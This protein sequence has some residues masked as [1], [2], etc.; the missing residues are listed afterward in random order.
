[1]SKLPT[2]QIKIEPVGQI[3]G[4]DISTVFRY[5]IFVTKYDDIY[6]SRFTRS[7]VTTGYTGTKAEAQRDAETIVDHLADR[8]NYLSYV[9]PA[10][11]NA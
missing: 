1:M 2:Y 11:D 9:Y 7:R 4:R 3:T 6:G 8:R 10:G 5:D